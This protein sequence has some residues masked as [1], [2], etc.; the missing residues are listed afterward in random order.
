MNEMSP[1]LASASSDLQPPACSV[2]IAAH[3]Y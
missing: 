3:A 2:V 1:V